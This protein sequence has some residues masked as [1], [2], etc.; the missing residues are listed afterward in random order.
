VLLLKAVAEG[1]GGDY[2][3]K[4]EHRL[5]TAALEWGI[6]IS[7]GDGRGPLT[8]REIA[9]RLAE[10][11]LSEFSLQ[12]G[13]LKTLAIA[14]VP[15]QAVWD[16]LGLAPGASTRRSSRPCTARTWASTTTSATSC[17]APSGP[18]WPTAGAA[19]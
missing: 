15:R 16:R 17:M 14:P 19:R 5:R 10:V 9:A 1:R 11:F 3:I 18:R 8:P 2:Q 6:D 7:G 4:D 13:K 12:E